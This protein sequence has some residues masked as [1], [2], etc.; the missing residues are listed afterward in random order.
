LDAYLGDPP[1]YPAA[2][3]A[4]PHLG[5]DGGRGTFRP[6]IV[7]LLVDSADVGQDAYDERIGGRGL[8]P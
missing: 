5:T 1:S 6:E 7:E 4:D 8:A 2:R 3:Q